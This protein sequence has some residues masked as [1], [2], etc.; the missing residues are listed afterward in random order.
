MDPSLSPA[1]LVS[2][3]SPQLLRR[4]GDPIKP[5]PRQRSHCALCKPSAEHV[6]AR[7]LTSQAVVL[8]FAMGDASIARAVTMLSVLLQRVHFW[9]ARLISPLTLK[10]VCTHRSVLLVCARAAVVVAWSA[11]KSSLGSLERYRG[12]WGSGVVLRC[13]NF[14]SLTLIQFL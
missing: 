8:V 10:K 4:W 6:C 13:Q 3:S 5:P 7:A 14:G 12:L 11:G 1:A 9:H 2:S